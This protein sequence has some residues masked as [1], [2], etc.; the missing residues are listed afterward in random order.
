MPYANKINKAI[1]NLKKIS[2]E[3]DLDFS[4]EIQ[5]LETKLSEIKKRKSGEWSDKKQQFSPWERVKLARTLERPKPQEYIDALLTDFIELQGDRLIGDDKAVKGGIGY[6][7]EIP[8]TAISTFRGKELKANMWSNFGMPHPEGYRKA[9]RL[10]RQAEKFN[11]PVLF[12]VDT[13]GAFCGIEAE[14]RGIAEAI[15]R[16]LYELSD[17]QVP[18]IT[19]ITGE[20]GS[21][22]ALALSV[23]N[24]LF[25]M[26]NAIFS[27]ISP[28]GC[29][30]ILFKDAAKAEEAA[31]SLRLTSYDLYELGVIDEIIPEHKEFNQKPDKTYHHLR[32]I[33]YKHIKELS[34][35]QTEKLIDQRYH[36]YRN[37]GFYETSGQATS[38]VATHSSSNL[39]GRFKHL[40][41]IK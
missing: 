11:R 36:K 29:A 31:K 12:F 16:N 15:A 38:F 5:G 9:L 23:S 33:L 13:P 24:R 19:V 40:F 10:A 2:S 39:I 28:E 4:Q 41:G 3:E 34:A 20:G 17:L 35:V 18:T 27:V 37:I 1:R 30:S 6:L 26:E 14:E 21:G 22:G 7:K 25:M 8:V 32:D